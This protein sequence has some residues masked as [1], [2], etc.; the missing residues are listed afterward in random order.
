MVSL[1]SAAASGTDTKTV[2]TEIGDQLGDMT[3][4]AR[5][6]FSF[7]GCH[8]DD[9]AILDDLRSRF[10]DAAILGGT[11]CGGVMNQG[12]LW[13]AES[14]GI[15]AI[16]DAAGDYGVGAAP[17]GDDPA[18]A[19]QHALAHALDAAGCPGELPE[20]VWLFQ[21]PG[22]EEAVVEGLRSV[23][24][25]RC[26][27]VGG[28]SADNS[29]S[30][31]WRQIGPGGVMMDGIVI[32]VLFPSGGIG[33]SFQGGYEP[34]G[35]SGVITRLGF[36]ASGANGIATRTNGRR[37]AEIDGKPAAT[38][39]NDWVGGSLGERLSEGGNI[40]LDTTMCPLAIDAGKV[41]GVPHYV[42]IHPETIT[43]DGALT[44]FAAIEE[45][46]QIFSMRGNRQNLIERAGRVAAQ[47]ASALPSGASSLAG[48]IVVYCAGC[49]LAVDDE[50]DQVVESVRDSFG[51][52]P[53]LGCFTFGEQGRIADRNVHGNL[54]IS[55]VAF[56]R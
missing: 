42:L 31:E 52:A 45:G 51:D 30:G 15:L 7:Y 44:T 37:I 23:I 46:A 10:P 11:S 4:P 36:E 19:A 12:H 6:V 3:G 9:Q 22:H 2:L 17:C 41:D 20:L 38:V 26:P 48:G 14:I 55:A 24:G 16:D 18:A 8:H 43:A 35:P 40:L 54:M 25:D 5:F 13:N 29:V 21:T 53:F 1:H 56:G 27:I 47:A 32:G 49:M 39:F 28:S 50:M 33:C 34:A